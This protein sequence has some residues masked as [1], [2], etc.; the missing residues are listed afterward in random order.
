MKNIVESPQMSNYKEAAERNQT[1]FLARQIVECWP[2]QNHE[3]HWVHYAINGHIATTIYT[4]SDERG[5]VDGTHAG[6]AYSLPEKVRVE[7]SS[8]L[9]VPHDVD[10]DAYSYD[11]DIPNMRSP[12]YKTFDL[13]TT[14][15][16]L[17]LPQPIEFDRVRRM[18]PVPF[19]RVKTPN[20]EFICARFD[21][22]AVLKL[23][24]V[25]KN[26]R[27]KPDQ[28]NKEV[29]VLLAAAREI[30][31]DTIVNQTMHEIFH[32]PT[33]EYI[34]LV[35]A[36]VKNERISQSVVNLLRDAMNS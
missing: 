10:I 15:Y 3:K 1:L 17:F 23:Q 5:I 31:G 4:F 25:P 21:Y 24:S 34:N 30:F 16:P 14:G 6:I 29:P 28:I 22:G 32:K 12:R 13:M 18:P 35:S 19:S 26:H 20:G 27:I 9:R 33:D 8:L 7:L 36:A 11:P 2:Q